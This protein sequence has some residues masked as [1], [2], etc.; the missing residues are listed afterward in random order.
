M[1]VGG[2]GG[3]GEEPA[4]GG[5]GGS[6]VVPGTAAIDIAD[7]TFE[8]STLPVASGS[9][10]IAVTNSDSTDHTFTLDDDSV[11]LEL[12]PGESETATVQIQETTGFH[13]EIHPS[14]TGTLQAD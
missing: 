4:D 12:A 11:N 6:D 14:M 1:V 8:P 9:T 7:F 10:D 2:C 5:G 13:C 3:N